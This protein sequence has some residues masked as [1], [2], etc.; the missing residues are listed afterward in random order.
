MANQV[1]MRKEAGELN[2]REVSLASDEESM[3]Q[4]P[5]PSQNGSIRVADTSAEFH[6]SSSGKEKRVSA[7]TS[8]PS[9]FSTIR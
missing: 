6:T 9:N 5:A 7:P 3:M 8:F 2:D 4:T 1:D